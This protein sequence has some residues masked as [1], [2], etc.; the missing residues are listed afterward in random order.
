[1][2]LEAADRRTFPVP[3]GLL[4]QKGPEQAGHQGLCAQE[5]AGAVGGE[6]LELRQL[7]SLLQMPP[8]GGTSSLHTEVAM[9]TLGPPLDLLGSRAANRSP[10]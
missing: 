1:M 10:P 9:G 2:K 7:P 5:L 6:G 8:S 4:H 3:A